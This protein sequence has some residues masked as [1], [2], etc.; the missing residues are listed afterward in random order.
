MH[1]R[2]S[3][4]W[5]CDLKFVFIYLMHYVIMQKWFRLCPTELAMVK[6]K[7]TVQVLSYEPGVC[8][9]MDGPFPPLCREG[10]LNAT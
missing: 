10:P 7:F 8:D 5:I 6:Q 9:K 4:L 1:N 3:H 2:K